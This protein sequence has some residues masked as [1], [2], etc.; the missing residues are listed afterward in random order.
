MGRRSTDSGNPSYTLNQ[1]TLSGKVLIW[2]AAF[3]A[4]VC[5]I[6]E[7]PAG[8]TDYTDH[9]LVRVYLTSQ[10]D[11][12]FMASISAT[13]VGD[14]AYVGWNYYTV[15][16][17]SYASLDLSGISFELRYDDY[18]A[19]INDTR[20]RLSTRTPIAP[21]SPSAYPLSLLPFELY[22]IPPVAYDWNSGTGTCDDLGGDTWFED[23]RDL[24][25]ID[26]KIDEWIAT[27]PGLVSREIIGTTGGEDGPVPIWAVRIGH[28]SINLNKPALFIDATQHARE[29][30]VPLAAMWIGDALLAGYGV[31]SEITQIVDQIEFIIVPVVNPEGYA[32][33]YNPSGEFGWRKNRHRKPGFPEC[34]GDESSHF[35]ID[36]NRNFETPEWLALNYHED[37][38]SCDVRYSNNT[39]FTENETQAI[40]DF[41]SA[42]S[43]IL[44][45]IDFHTYAKRVLRPFAYSDTDKPPQ[46]DRNNFLNIAEGMVDEINSVT[47]DGGYEHAVTALGNP[48]AGTIRD[49]AYLHEGLY[50]FTIELRPEYDGNGDIGDFCPMLEQVTRSR[51]EAMA[52]AKY[53]ASWLVGDNDGDSIDNINDNCTEVGN[54]DQHDCDNDG[55]GNVCDDDVCIEFYGVEDSASNVVYDTSGPAGFIMSYTSTPSYITVNYRAFGAALNSSGGLAPE[56]DHS[57]Q[58][59]WCSCE[60]YSNDSTGAYNCKTLNCIQDGPTQYVTHYH[61][62][63]WHLVSTHGVPGALSVLDPPPPSPGTNHCNDILGSSVEDYVPSFSPSCDKI[64][65]A[66]WTDWGLDE[67]ISDLC[68]FHCN[69]PEHEFENPQT[70]SVATRSL[71]WDWDRELWWEETVSDTSL[72]GQP[73]SLEAALKEDQFP[74]TSEHDPVWGYLWV[75]PE[76]EN[77]NGRLWSEVN[78][79]ETF[80]LDPGT[81]HHYHKGI[82]LT[83]SPWYDFPW[84]ILHPFDSLGRTP[85]MRVDPAISQVLPHVDT[86]RF[87]MGLLSPGI[88]DEAGVFK[89]ADG[90]VDGDAAIGGLQI[91]FID[92]HSLESGAWGYSTGDSPGSVPS[93]V[94]FANAM[95][96]WTEDTGSVHGLA[97]FGGQSISGVK[98]DTLWLGQFGGLD[99][100]GAP[101]FNWHDETPMSGQ[102]PPPRNGAAMVFDESQKRLIMFGG[103]MERDQVANDIWAYDLVQ[104]SWNQLNMDFLSLTNFSMVQ[105]GGR[106]FV[107]GGRDANGAVNTNVY[108]VNFADLQYEAIADLANGPGARQGVSMGF[109]A[110]GSGSLLFYGGVDA[111]GSGR[112]DL[113]SLGLQNQGWAGIVPDCT[114]GACPVSDGPSYLIVGADGRTSV[115]T[116]VNENGDD[117]FTLDDTGE[118]VGNRTSILQTTGSMDCDS[119]GI[120]EVDTSKAC[121]SSNE[122]YAE[123]STM[124]CAE[125]NESDLLECGAEVAQTM[126]LAESWSPGGWEWI[127]DLEEGPDD[128]TYV[129]TEDVL[130][131]FDTLDLSDGL[132]P[133]DSDSITVPGSCW[134]CGGP[135]WSFDV[136]VYGDKAF[137]ASFSGVHVFDL[138]DPSS[139]DEVGYFASY[140]PV[141]DMAFFNGMM[142]LADGFGITVVDTTDPAT[143]TEVGRVSLGTLVE[144]VGVNEEGWRLMA[145]TP[146]V[147]KKLDLGRDPFEPVV[148]DSI[149]IAGG[150][151]YDIKV[152]GDWTYLNGLFT[153]TVLDEGTTGLSTR[154]AHDLRDWV[155]GRVQR[156][157]RAERVRWLFGE[158]QVWEVD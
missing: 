90:L 45:L 26:T 93:T 29:W 151:F 110:S 147:L 97:V 137:V 68:S 100:E 30:V 105:A 144:A 108:R 73:T 74:L 99:S 140:A 35:G 84:I 139:P 10:P 57:V 106:F 16:P 136:E 67:E 135:D 130:Y 81:W 2:V 92:G 3:L 133:I 152:A 80:H 41:I 98:S 21:F 72:I 13:L 49:W 37:S 62:S 47:G 118:W 148:T 24:T 117:T 43:N 120:N 113:W 75:R 146:G 96:G 134:F 125:P 60:G 131:A 82:P 79:Y 64:G 36:L 46:P 54:P 61:H 94:G 19:Y 58:L 51:H 150:L 52:A 1:R 25:E 11:E 20:T 6:R 102:M 116:S 149:C 8:A 153:Q 40:R 129:L 23:W 85:D 123:V 124:R 112:N 66:G 156:G 12:D 109:D 70:T 119:D 53:L 88:G 77:E 157:D 48:L 22:G 78:K 63:G 155:D 138:S 34:D 71:Y 31:D 142:Y 126:S 143:P 5:V 69:P 15:P 121:R 33:T 50:A 91:S 38:Q 89:Y 7:N 87:G 95:Y 14:R 132:Y 39:W 76:G 114:Q 56:E 17:S 42:N 44:G 122:W 27:Y 4:V 65:S 111:S 55:I 83:P 158:F 128:Y 141:L 101:F 154:G 32:W 145:L 115:H 127:M 9:K 18:Q 86:A 104:E 103:T 59:R 28:D 107:A